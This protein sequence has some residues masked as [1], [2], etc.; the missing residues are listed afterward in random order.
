M[1]PGSVSRVT[2]ASS[3]AA[4]VELREAEV[5]NLHA[6]AGRAHDVFRFQVAMDNTP[7]VGGDQCV[8]NLSRGGQRP[9]R[10]QRPLGQFF[11]QRAALQILGG[12]E[13]LV[14]HF[15]ECVDGGDGRV[16]QRA[17]G[18][19]LVPQ[20]RPHQVVSEQVGRQRLQRHRPVQPRV[21]GE[22]DHAHAATTENADDSVGADVRAGR[23][24][25][26]P[27]RG[28]CRPG[29]EQ[30]A[31]PGL[32]PARRRARTSRGRM[33]SCPWALPR[34][35]DRTTPPTCRHRAPVIPRASVSSG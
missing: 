35:R 8:R 12:D 32:R 19:C 24:Q 16:R 28:S 34:A 9:L 25:A 22:I 11:A 4:D 29:R 20:P 18:A 3:S 1:T 30:A 27:A 7:L 13:R 6:A 14:A 5:Q 17:R 15:L 10:R 2:D 33:R 21:F 26:A 31:A 23:Q